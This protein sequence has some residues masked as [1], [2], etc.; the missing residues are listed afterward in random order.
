MRSR[1][2]RLL[3]NIEEDRAVFVS[4]YPNIFYYS[5]FAS[6]DGWLIISRSERYLI[7]D[8]RYF[9]Q[10]KEQAPDFCVLDIEQGW[11]KVFERVEEDKIC[12]E[13]EK[14]T[15]A[16][17]EKLQA[18][19]RGKR[20]FK[21]QKLID[22][23]RYTKDKEELKIIEEAESIGDRAFSHMLEFMKA[24]MTERE[25]ALELEM[26]MKKLGASGLSFTTIA[27]SGERSAMPHG[28][29]T[30][31]VVKKGELLTL[32][33]GCVYKGYCSDM[34]RTVVFG[35]PD[36]K[37]KEIYDI[38]LKAQQ[39]A[40]D[41]IHEGIL[42]AA[43]DRLARDVIKEAGYG[44]H[45]GHSLGHSVGIEIHEMPCFSPKSKDKLS[46]GN[47][48]SVEPGIYIDGWGGVRIEDLIAVIDGKIVNFAHSPKNLIVI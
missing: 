42:C 33:F 3:E 8:S 10:A 37:Q 25:I 4:G 35:E 17:F 47:V 48:L 22:A 43:A 38:V 12:F 18:K 28:V 6:E 34:T 26:T 9:V 20:F 45:F 36:G 44:K 23:Q 1:I 27:A 39:T 11:E 2:D 13:E 30:D 31:K 21:A 46:E 19:S 29:A 16:F 5:G 7:T 24:G 41:G 15:F 32:D 14:I 40:L